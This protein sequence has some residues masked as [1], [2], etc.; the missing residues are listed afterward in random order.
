MLIKGAGA[1]GAFN[2]YPGLVEMQPD[3][4]K[5]NIEEQIEHG[6]Y[7]DYI[8]TTIKGGEEFCSTKHYVK[9]I[10]TLI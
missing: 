2:S 7:D 1:V 10:E 9:H 4:V 8:K 3:V 5:K 6:R